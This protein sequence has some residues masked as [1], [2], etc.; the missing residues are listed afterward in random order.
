MLILASTLSSG[1][2]QASKQKKVDK[3]I[4]D[5]ESFLAAKKR[6]SAINRILQEFPSLSSKD[7]AEVFQMYQK[8]SRL[9]YLDRNQQA[10]ETLLQLKKTEPSLAQTRLHEL[11][12]KESHHLGLAIEDVRLDIQTE[13]CKEGLAKTEQLR[14]RI[15]FDEEVNLLHAFTL[16][17]QQKLT[18]A[19]LQRL[20][21]ETFLIEKAEIWKT[22]DGLV[23]VKVGTAA[24]SKATESSPVEQSLNTT[25]PEYDYYLW[26]KS[27]ATK[28]PRVSAA[29]KYLESCKS[30]TGKQAQ[31]WGWDPFLCRRT[32]EVESDL[33]K[34]NKKS[35]SSE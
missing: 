13:K 17:C 30:I 28:L 23:Q 32:A 9:F 20:K 29:N 35:D 7:K 33:A 25:Y 31:D 19:T 34:L 10:Y 11:M 16:Y 2:A 8:A 1:I 5:V 18:V 26:K 3:I 21:K 6:D 15:N 24:S 22:L 12:A 14:K 27:L 4:A